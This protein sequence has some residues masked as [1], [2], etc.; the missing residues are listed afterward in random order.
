M[1]SAPTIHIQYTIH[2]TICLNISF[3]GWPKQ[4]SVVVH[5]APLLDQPTVPSNRF[6]ME[7]V[8]DVVHDAQINLDIILH[9]PTTS[10]GSRSILMTEP[11]CLVDSACCLLRL[12]SLYT[13]NKTSGAYFNTFLKGVKVIYF[14]Y[15]SLNN[16][17]YNNTL[18]VLFLF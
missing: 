2:C 14:S 4:H 13:Q 10:S 17:M 8:Q 15:I 18:V 5:V 16:T 6:V 9:S 12:W 3:A 11:A 7:V 1:Y